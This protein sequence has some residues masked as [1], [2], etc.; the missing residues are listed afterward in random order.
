MDNT[1]DSRDNFIGE[2]LTEGLQRY[3]QVEVFSS[4]TT[5]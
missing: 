1:T 3:S 2:V 4:R 5:E